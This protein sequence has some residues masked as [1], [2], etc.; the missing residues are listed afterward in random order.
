VLAGFLFLAVS[1]FLAYPQVVR[2]ATVRFADFSEIQPGMYCSKGTT[3]IQQQALKSLIQK[4]QQRLTNFWGNTH[5]TPVIIFCHHT[6][7][8][9]RYGSGYGNPA[10]YFGS[11]L[12]S[13]V[14]VSPQGL[15]V[16][17]ISHEM[18][19]A[20]LTERLGWYTMT[21]QVPQWFNEG[22]ALMVDYRFPNEA[23]KVS[24]QKYRQRWK[25]LTYGSSFQLSVEDLE[26]I[27]S[28]S[29]NDA[30]S[31]QLAYMRSGMEVARWLQQVQRKGLVRF[32]QHIQEGQDFA[33]AY[34]E[35]A[36]T[37]G[38]NK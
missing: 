34:Q 17:I 21:T 37:S 7:L 30:Y 12:G 26:E 33:Q 6:E 2:C 25:E 16:D 24:Y 31:L 1:Y 38:I 8:Y 15:D 20:E 3:A 29:Q 9:E 4:S 13:F 22:L 36:Q 11:P 10:N 5:S 18:C 28:F 27:E 19:H 35:A 14:V 23:G 32:I